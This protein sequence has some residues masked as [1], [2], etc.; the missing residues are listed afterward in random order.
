[1]TAAKCDEWVP[2]RPGTLGALALGIAYVLISSGA[3]KQDFVDKWCFGYEDFRD[4]QGKTHMGFKRMVLEQYTL[5]RVADITGVD[6]GTIAKIAGE[7]GASSRALA[8]A[9]TGRGDLAGGNGLFTAMAIQ[10]LNALVGSIEV[11][12]GI[13]TQQYPTFAAGRPCRWTP[14]RKRGARS[15]VS[16]APGPPIR[17]PIRPARIFRPTCWA[18]SRTRQ[19]PC[20]C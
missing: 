9:P 7:F 1:M 15:R 5:A 18:S 8:I 16:M 6:S 4:D 10:S 11:P 12:G 17:W 13:L 20:S 14:P 3:V 2:V 19:M